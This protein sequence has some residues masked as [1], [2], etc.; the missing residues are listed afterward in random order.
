M[1]GR[2]AKPA[3]AVRGAPRRV[4]RPIRRLP[5][6]ANLSPAPSPHRPRFR[7]DHCLAPS[8][9]IILNIFIAKYISLKSPQNNIFSFQTKTH[10]VQSNMI[11]H[12]C[13][14]TRPNDAPR[15]WLRAAPRR[16]TIPR[17]LH[18]LPGIPGRTI[19]TT[20]T[21]RRLTPR[22]DSAYLD[23]DRIPVPV[24]FSPGTDF[25]S[26]SMCCCTKRISIFEKRD[27]V[28]ILVSDCLILLVG[29]ISP[30]PTV[31]LF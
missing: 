13:H 26:S 22:G 6:A 4:G 3:L 17:P 19:P 29:I 30:D 25:L 14:H 7:S 1:H 23:I 15:N 9:Q 2:G 27:L 16:G 10:C 5:P 21:L 31:S 20:K 28:L 12:P 24:Y 18:P 8:H 11:M